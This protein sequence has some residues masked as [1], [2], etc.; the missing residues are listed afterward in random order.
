[1]SDRFLVMGVS[2]EVGSRV[3]EMLRQDGHAAVGASRTSKGQNWVRFDWLDPK[4]YRPALQ[5]TT[6][7]LLICRPGDEEADRYAH[8]GVDGAHSR[9]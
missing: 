2:G 1:M 5:G 3:L 9:R 7:V 4:T 6:S 8:S